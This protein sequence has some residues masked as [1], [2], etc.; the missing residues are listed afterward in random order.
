MNKKLQYLGILTVSV[1]AGCMGD[2]E[3][4]G[5]PTDTDT[6]AA[7]APSIRELARMK[8]FVEHRTDPNIV[9]RTLRTKDGRRVDCV[10]IA[11]QP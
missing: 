10:D 7:A 2:E 5:D 9:R 4:V 11:R 6:A 1:L 3:S 8:D